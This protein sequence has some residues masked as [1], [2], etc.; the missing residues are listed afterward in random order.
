M[1]IGDVVSVYIGSKRYPRMVKALGNLAGP[2]VVVVTRTGGV[3][4]RG[5]RTVLDVV[6]SRHTS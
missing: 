2:L 5:V 6:V 4:D 1:K 3:P